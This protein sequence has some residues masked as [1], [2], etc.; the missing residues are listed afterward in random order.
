MLSS[1]QRTDSVTVSTGRTDAFET[2][3]MVPESVDVDIDLG[4]TRESHE[5]S[6]EEDWY[7]MTREDID[8]GVWGFTSDGQDWEL[9]GSFASH[10]FFKDELEEA[11]FESIA[12]RHGRDRDPLV[13]RLRWARRFRWLLALL[14]LIASGILGWW[15]YQEHYRPIVEAEPNDSVA[16][17]NPIFLGHAI[18][19]YIG[20]RNISDAR[21][22]ADYYRI[23]LNGNRFVEV[24]LSGVP[25]MDLVLDVSFPEATQGS[26]ERP[27]LSPQMTFDQAGIGETEHH[28]VGPF[29]ADVLY[30]TVR[31]KWDPSVEPTENSTDPYEL[32]VRKVPS[33][34]RGA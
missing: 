30:L 17:A 14:L 13:T 19:G 15:V 12:S 11:T 6:L 21:S 10:L 33:V 5:A 18:S 16:E 8:S 25:R 32:I 29:D 27:R 28:I 24:T 34:Q 31:E 26:D 3:G 23:E 4:L 9:D 7:A 1:D 20:K 22:D 2:S